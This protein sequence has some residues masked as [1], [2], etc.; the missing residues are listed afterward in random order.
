M[1]PERLL[2][3]LVRG[4][5]EGGEIRVEWRLGVDHQVAC[6]GHVYDQIRTQRAFLA[7][8]LQLLGEVAVLAEAGELHQA[9]QCQLAPTAAHLRAAQ[10]GDQ[11]ARLALQLR[12]AAGE[13]LDLGAQGREGVA[14]LALECLHLRL[15]ALERDAQRLHQVR[16]GQLAFLECALG[17]DL[18]APE[19]LA[20]EAQEQ[21]AVG[22]QCLAGEGIERGAQA[23]LGLL[24]QLQPV[25]VL[26]EARFQAHLRGG[27]LDP[28]RLDAPHGAQLRHQ[29]A[30]HRAGGERGHGNDENDETAHRWK[31]AR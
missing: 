31:C 25:R 4:R 15:G 19:R 22:A 16:D 30:Q 24:E 1:S 12:L 5:L 23:R 8:H 17:D 20:R 18:V 11:I 14:A 28:Q 7:D 6:I 29:R 26:Q 27:Q 21:L 3:L 9:A 2:A 13:R 10:R